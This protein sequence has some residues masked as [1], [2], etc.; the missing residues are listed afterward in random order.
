MRGCRDVR[1]YLT[2]DLRGCRYVR[3]MVHVPLLI[4][5]RRTVATAG[6]VGSEDNFSMEAPDAAAGRRQE[7]HATVLSAS[8][9]SSSFEA[10]LR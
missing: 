4:L 1:G 9:P 10:E 2:Q 5:G 3:G 6:G 7:L 8:R